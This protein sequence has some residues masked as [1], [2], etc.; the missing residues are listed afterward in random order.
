MLGAMTAEQTFTTYLQAFNRG[1]VAA[2]AGM[3]AP[4][5]RFV[6]PFSPEPLRTPAAILAFVSSMFGAYDQLGAEVLDQVTTESRVAARLRMGGRQTG[7]LASPD[8]GA[9]EASGRE[10]SVLTAEFFTV[11][12]A[13]RITEHVRFFDTGALVAQVAGDAAQA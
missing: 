12:D 5:T 9:Y 8:G 11:D 10:V 3:Y 2:M 4:E 1:D 6:N 7:T 13:G